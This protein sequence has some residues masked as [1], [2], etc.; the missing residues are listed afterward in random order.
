MAILLLIAIVTFTV[1]L[2]IGLPA[3]DS[4][5]Q[6]ANFKD[7][8]AAARLLDNAIRNVASEG[9]GATRVL[10]FNS[11]PLES[12]PD[13][14]AFEFR[15]TAST[16]LLEYLTRRFTGNIV[17]VS[18]SDVSCSDNGRNITAENGRISV[19][20]QKIEK[21]APAASIDTSKN[22]LS[23]KEKSS[24]TT[25]AIINSSIV[26]DGNQ[27]TSTGTGYSQLLR[28]GSS[29][30]SC[31]VFFFVNSTSSD[32]DVYYTLY[33]GADFVVIDVKNVR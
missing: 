19:V 22:I 1:V 12:L 6:I 25:I 16:Q 24:A 11:P 3:V 27:S 31:S 15:M 23:V 32:Y 4:S 10:E 29:L 2:G 30:S 13:E 9:K 28:S 20:F 5:R 14:D 8:E 33:S 18:G 17:Y 21:T 7:A 26:L